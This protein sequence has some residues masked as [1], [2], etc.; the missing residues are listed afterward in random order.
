MF[1]SFICLEGRITGSSMAVGE[2]A[3]AR[4]PGLIDLAWKTKGAGRHLEDVADA[5]QRRMQVPVHLETPQSR[6]RRRALDP[7]DQRNGN[8]DIDCVA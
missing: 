7:V 5:E 2:P 1:F 6:R 4:L 3:L 8:F